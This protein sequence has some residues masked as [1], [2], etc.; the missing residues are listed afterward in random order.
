[1]EFKKILNWLDNTQN[2]PS[3]FRTKNWVKINDKSRETHNVSN[4]I[5]PETSM[6]SSNLWS[7]IRSNIAM[8]IYMI[9]EL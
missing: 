5:K 1:M 8:H 7:N 9:K 4:Q 6:I 2:E 3:K